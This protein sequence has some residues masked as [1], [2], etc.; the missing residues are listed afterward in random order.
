MKICFVHTPMSTIDLPEREGYWRT[1]DRRYHASH[2]GLTE[3]R[4]PM[5]ELPHWTTWLAGTLIEK[6]FSNL[7]FVDFRIEENNKTEF[8]NL[9]KKNII[10]TEADVFLFSPMTSNLSKA[11]RLSAIVK[12][13]NEE[14]VTIFG[15]NTASSLKESLIQ[16]PYID[17]IIFGRG[18]IALPNLLKKLPNIENYNNLGNI[19][20]KTK[21]GV[22]ISEFLHPAIAMN[23]LPLPYL[24]IIP[25]EYGQDLRYLR[26]VHGLGC[27]YK[28]PF[29]SI[30]TIGQKTCYFSVH[31]TLSEIS[32]YKNYFGKH[33]NIYFGDETFFSDEKETRKLLE[34]VS[35]I[36]SIKY[37]CQTRLNLLTE[38][39][40][41][42]LMHSGCSW[43][44]VGL[45]TINQNTLGQFKQNLSVKSIEDT[46][47]LARDY[48]IPVCSY[49][50][51]GFPNQSIK[52][53]KESIDKVAEFIVSGLLHASY[54][55][56]LVPYPGSLLY[57]NPQKYGLNIIT[58]DLDAFHEDLLPVYET[59]LA[60]AEEI[61]TVFLYG[62][63]TLAE[64]MDSMPYLFSPEFGSKDL[65]FGSFWSGNHT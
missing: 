62:L 7:C 38:L 28:C 14:A 55:F 36:E 4:Y 59:K 5:W 34:T 33:L 24:E 47:K 44:E 51:N 10:K 45:E 54:F 13:V 16:S 32:M 17:Y 6:G 21:T 40:C 63:K 18:E 50:I 31:R 65:S 58:T 37:D 39:N 11:I 23:K 12:E 20:C 43:L 61:Y 64:A 2:I 19:A 3:M 29:C 53:M 27:P 52:S 57:N 46:L 22:F 9:C 60:N 30:Q 35:D 26:I 25:K 42:S 1:F 48:G 41:N 15:G 49:I 56:G 8:D